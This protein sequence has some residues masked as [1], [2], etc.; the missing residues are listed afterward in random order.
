MLLVSLRTRLKNSFAKRQKVMGSPDVLF[1]SGI[2]FFLIQGA[3]SQRTSFAINCGGQDT[4]SFTGDVGN[5]VPSW[6]SL[7]GSPQA[8]K[9]GGPHPVNGPNSKYATVAKTHKWGPQTS[10]I[11]YSIS[12]LA[13]GIWDCELVFAET[14]EFFKVPGK[15]VF[16]AQIS[17]SGSTRRLTDID[18]YS[19]VGFYQG[20]S[21]VLDGLAVTSQMSVQFTSISGSPII[22]AISCSKAEGGGGGGGVEEEFPTSSSKLGLVIGLCVAGAALIVAAIVIVLFLHRKRKQQKPRTQ[23]SDDSPDATYY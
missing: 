4:G 7:S 13:S 1:L 17:S 5:N 11:S 9:D 6:I 18:V 2:L 21:Y 14:S 8:P 16:N 19:K 12:G 10:S 22:S 20:T 3:H 15:R 23:E